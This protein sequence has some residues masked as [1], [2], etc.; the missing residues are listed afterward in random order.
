MSRL[1]IKISPEVGYSKEALEGKEYLWA[2]VPGDIHTC[3][4]KGG[5]SSEGGMPFL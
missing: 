5:T 1:N 2:P 4:L 3:A